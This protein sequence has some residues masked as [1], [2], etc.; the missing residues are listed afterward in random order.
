M[1]IF[2]AIKVNFSTLVLGMAFALVIGYAVGYFLRKLFTEYQI[3]EAEARRQ[4]IIDEA[5][6]EVENR[7]KSAEIEAREKSL[8]VKSD[9]EK[10]I[11]VKRDSFR[12]EEKELEQKEREFRNEFGKF[13]TREQEIKTEF[14][15]L[16]EKKIEVEK[17][18]VEYKRLIDEEIK[19]LEVI[20]SYTAEKAREEVQNKIVDE[21]KLDA[22]REVKKIEEKVKSQADDE[23]RKLITMA[24]QRLASDHVAETTVAVV[25]LPSDDIKGRIIGR[26]G[27]NIRALEQAT[28]IDL[29]ID[30]T[31]GAVVLSGFDPIR[32]EVAR[33]ALEYLTIDGRI[34]PGRIEDV[35][36]KCKKEVTE[37]IQKS[38]EQAVI[39]VGLD[40]INP[41]MVKLLGRLKYR[42]S[43]TQNV[44]EH[45][46]EVAFVCGSIAV[47]LGLNENM[48]KRA[49]LLHDIG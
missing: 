38:G 37:E 15:K 33:R 3:K 8:A 13:K 39:N 48:A 26:E 45:V 17:Q 41:E 31:P 27:R 20:G 9:F 32:R 36:G 14:A 19:K 47:E 43:Y 29:I 46:Q 23:A 30:D 40:N 1:H 5:E 28:G 2:T 4:K 16:N 6:K 12:D 24:V 18:K 7:L 10:E 42:T 44:L 21:A 35:V 11:K 34:H 22:A 25:E 49:G